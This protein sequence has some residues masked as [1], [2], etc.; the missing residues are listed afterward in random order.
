MDTGNELKIHNKDTESESIKEP[1]NKDTTQCQPKLSTS[2]GLP[3]LPT[4]A[5]GSEAEKG[6]WQRLSLLRISL[7]PYSKDAFPTVQ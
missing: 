7:L 1:D 6:P 3:S 2:T 5:V 4:S